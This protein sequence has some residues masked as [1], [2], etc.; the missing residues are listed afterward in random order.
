MWVCLSNF[1][2]CKILKTELF[3]LD[4]RKIFLESR[5]VINVFL[6]IKPHLKVQSVWSSENPSLLVNARQ[7]FR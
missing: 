6:H 7:D 1:Q 3:I 4:I 2:I 5:I